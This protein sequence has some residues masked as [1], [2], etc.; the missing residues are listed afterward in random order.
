MN[1]D[2][3]VRDLL[4]LSSLR[5]SWNRLVM[6]VSNYVPSSNTVKFDDAVG[7][8]LSK[9]MRRKSTGETLGN[10]L[11]MERRGIQVDGGRRPTNRKKYRK[12]RSKYR[13]GNTECWNCGERGISKKDCINTN[14]IGDG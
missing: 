1:F 5:E 3:E 6:V 9:E 12:G 14:K 2:D 4:I 7:V 13:F 11:T 8:I 10:A